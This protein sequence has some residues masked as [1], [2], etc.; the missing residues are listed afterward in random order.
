[1]KSRVSNRDLL[2][3]ESHNFK[4]FKIKEYTCKVCSTEEKRRA[5]TV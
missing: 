4:I 3:L 5:K 1:M 2:K